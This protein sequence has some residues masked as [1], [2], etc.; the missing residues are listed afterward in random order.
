MSSVA[1]WA[2][3][4]DQQ[5]LAK[6][7]L[8]DKPEKV[9]PFKG[10]QGRDTAEQYW[11][12]IAIAYKTNAL[13]DAQ[14]RP[15]TLNDRCGFQSMND[16]KKKAREREKKKEIPYFGKVRWF[17][18]R[19]HLF[20]SA[21]IQLVRSASIYGN[22]SSDN[23]GP[24]YS[25]LPSPTICH[26]QT[27]AF[28]YATEAA[29]EREWSGVDLTKVAEEKEE[30]SL[31]IPEAGRFI[32][33]GAASRAAAAQVEVRWELPLGS[34]V[35]EADPGVVPGRLCYAGTA[36]LLL[37]HWCV[38][39]CM[40]LVPPPGTTLTAFRTGPAPI[41]C[42]M[43]VERDTTS[44]SLFCCW[45]CLSLSLKGNL[46]THGQKSHTFPKMGTV[47]QTYIFF[48]SLNTFVNYP[49]Q[50]LQRTTYLL[51]ILGSTTTL[52]SASREARC[53]NISLLFV[54]WS[55]RLTT[56]IWN[57]LQYIGVFFKKWH[58]RIKEQSVWTSCIWPLDKHFLS[59][60]RHNY[61]SE[62]HI[63]LPFIF[64]STFPLSILN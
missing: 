12:V 7:V 18:V 54:G 36:C 61:F 9:F 57:C 64:T 17:P 14:P 37:L 11:S 8:C 42:C 26:S 24:L 52:Q 34:D 44:C 48:L 3:K 40:Q 32:C 2:P 20:H 33:H 1:V 31:G 10:I 49:Y 63:Q 30:E 43:L 60:G 45:T 39:G 21:F 47:G 16:V 55:S 5:A 51:N 23:S 50:V 46:R 4:P 62:Y 35:L 41:T 27:V 53:Y 38:C 25:N 6:H 22:N 59:R 13:F 29:R 28:Q 15:I 19:W 56:T 58:V